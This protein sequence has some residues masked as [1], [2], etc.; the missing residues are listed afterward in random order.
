MRDAERNSQVALIQ[1][2]VARI[3]KSSYEY[4]K[5]DLDSPVSSCMSSKV[6]RRSLP[7]REG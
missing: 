7:V 4:E 5:K 2:L 3:P 1:D 6:V